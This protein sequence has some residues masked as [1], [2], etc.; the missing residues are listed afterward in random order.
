MA[1]ELRGSGAGR[2]QSQQY[3]MC[4][5][6]QAKAGREGACSVTVSG[7]RLA[8]HDRGEGGRQEG[9]TGRL[10]LRTL[11]EAASLA[12]LGKVAG[13]EMCDD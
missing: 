1:Y 11:D 2:T 5:P 6:E 13:G 7:A 10:I 9:R 8:C 4:F 12:R 3:R